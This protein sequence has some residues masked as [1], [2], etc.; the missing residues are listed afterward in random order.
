MCLLPVLQSPNQVV[1][2]APA[3]L[4]RPA[5]SKQLSHL[6]VSVVEHRG[7]QADEN[8]ASVSICPKT[9]PD[10]RIQVLLFEAPQVHALR[11][12]KGCVLEWSCTGHVESRFTHI[13][14]ER[15]PVEDV[16]NAAQVMSS[17]VE[18]GAF[19]GNPSNRHWC[20][21]HASGDGS[22]EIGRAVESLQVAGLLQAIYCH[23]DR[24]AWVLSLEA[25]QSLQFEMPLSHPQPL[26]QQP[27]SRPTLTWTRLQLLCLLD[28]LGW[29]VHFIETSRERRATAPL[30]LEAAAQP[31]NLLFFKG[32]VSRHYLCCV[33]LAAVA[34]IGL[35]FPEDA[36]KVIHHFETLDY[37]LQLL[38]LACEQ[39]RRKR[40]R[41]VGVG[42]AIVFDAPEI[43]DPGLFGA[44]SNV[45]NSGP[46]GSQADPGSGDEPEPEVVFAPEGAGAGAGSGDEAGLQ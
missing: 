9:T 10:G 17:L 19:A 32:R 12:A 42:E 14:I 24:S 20:F 46:G 22:R 40:Q 5:R 23:E 31:Q 25:Q 3:Q 4:K 34:P 45:D 35:H 6:D 13:L 16:Q 41:G 21:A 38:G 37:Y 15:L 39:Q 33:A 29:G 2:R 30:P 43:D 11:E 26:C 27:E 44:R 7:T 1:H 8:T 28:E 36:A 18:I